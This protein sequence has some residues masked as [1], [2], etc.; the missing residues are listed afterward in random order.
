MPFLNR[1]ITRLAL[2]TI[3][4]QLSK[5]IGV[6]PVDEFM[7]DMGRRRIALRAVQRGLIYAF[8]GQAPRKLAS[9]RQTGKR[10]L[11]LYFGERQLGDA[12]MDLA[13]RTLLQKRGY[14]MDLLTDDSL[15]VVFQKDPWFESVSAK[16]NALTCN[17]Y[18][19]AIVLNNK[20]RAIACKR[21]FFKDLPWVS[22]HE[23]F[24]GPNF[25]RAAFAT[26]RLADLLGLDLT[27]QEF[28]FHANQKL[29]N[30]G[31]NGS[32][33]VYSMTAKA[34]NTAVA[35]C[36]GG[37]DPLRTYTAW[38]PLISQLVSSGVNEYILIGSSNGDAIARQIEHQFQENAV[39]RNFV[40]KCSVLESRE[41]IANSRLAIST[42]GGLLHLAATTNTPI[43]G[44]F[45]RNIPPQWRLQ[46]Q[47]R[48]A[49]LSSATLDVNDISPTLVA[50]KT[51]AFLNEV[52]RC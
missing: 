34:P 17:K 48:S 20:R 8:S 4:P 26:Q 5:T 51:M 33:G 41:L 40:G 14:R 35:L 23:N 16:P 38:G 7:A 30:C 39:I 45:C 24:A 43:L 49:D 22:V 46:A 28:S 31:A 47:T 11:W 27:P 44:L 29:G 1:V 18:D 37:V 10:G 32:D 50:Q 3:V 13:P 6:D 2:G 21:Q 19:F 36:V 42:D 25:D 12:L 15:A 9:L 52:S